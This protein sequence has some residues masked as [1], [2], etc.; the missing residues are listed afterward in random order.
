MESLRSIIPARIETERLYLRGFR[1]G[2][3]G[4]Y[5]SV[6][7]KNGNHLA[8]YESDN[9]VLAAKNCEEAEDIVR[10]LA[11]IWEERKSFFLAGFEM[12]TDEFVVQ[13]YIGPVNVNLP[14]YQIGYFVDQCHEGKGYATE[15]VKAALKFTFGNLGAYR[16]SLECD[17]T[18]ARSWRVA[19]RCGMVK[20][21]H[22]R[23]NKKNSDGTFSGTMYYGL[24]RSEFK[25]FEG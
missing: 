22:R 5:Y 8:K 19:E 18:N 23:E 6:G 16:V 20:E 14:E 2:D 21:G 7:Q 3:G 15:A 11:T 4:W 13:I 12:G 10:E 17:D 1:P 9:V 24:L 25:T